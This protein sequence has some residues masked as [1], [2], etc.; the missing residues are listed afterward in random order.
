[1]STFSE[2]VN[3][4]F[5]TDDEIFAKNT[6][7]TR[8]RATQLQ[9][10]QPMLSATA[11]RAFDRIAEI[12]ADPETQTAIRLSLEGVPVSTTPI[13]IPRI[14]GIGSIRAKYRCTISQAGFSKG[15]LVS[16]L[17]KFIRRGET[18]KAVWCALEL[19][20]FS[21]LDRPDIL[22][23]Y[24]HKFHEDRKV[25]STVQGI[26]TNLMNRLNIISVEDVGLGD[27]IVRVVKDLLDKWNIG[28]R[29]N[30]GLLISAVVILSNCRKLRLLSDLKSV[31]HLP[32]YY[33]SNDDQET[34]I[35][36]FIKTLWVV[37]RVD[38][39]IDP[40]LFATFERVSRI[41]KDGISQGLKLKQI[42]NHAH[43]IWLQL[44]RHDNPEIRAL[45]G[46]F[47][48]AD[49]EEHPLYLYQA[50]LIH[51][52]K[53]PLP[54][55]P[56]PD[57]SALI[58]E[59]TPL[60]LNFIDDYCNDKHVAGSG[61][62][63]VVRFAEEGALVKN[64][65]PHPFPPFR[66]IYIDLKKAIEYN[67]PIA[68][69]EEMALVASGNLKAPLKKTAKQRQAPK[70]GRAT[71]KAKVEVILI[72]EASAPVARPKKT[73]ATKK[74]K[75]PC[76]TSG[77]NE[78]S[79]FSFLVRAQVL[80]SNNK[81]D[82]YFATMRERVGDFSKGDFVLVKGPIPEGA[83]NAISMNQWKRDNHLPHMVLTSLNLRPDMWS[84]GTPL[85]CRNKLDRSC[86]YP[87]LISASTL[88]QDVILTNTITYKEFKGRDYNP[89]GQ[90]PADTEIVN[91]H[92]VTSHIEFANK[93]F[94]LTS[95]QMQ[96]YVLLL[97]A[98]WLFGISDLADRNFLIRGDHVYSVDEEYINHP[99][100][101]VNELKTNKCAAIIEWLRLH[102]DTV[103][104]NVY[105]WNVPNEMLDIK[106]RTLL[107]KSECI[108]LF[109]ST[110]S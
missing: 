42:I 39:S 53:P 61:E 37:H 54:H 2:E 45:H 3:F 58:E 11:I 80:T 57:V 38:A 44:L 1:M 73:R 13:F 87:F 19:D 18:R 110:S 32:K 28:G 30:Q 105:R 59:L 81:A 72:D 91:W 85:G 33:G 24:T 104:A 22:T 20:G 106:K 4:I 94:K 67:Q 71:K 64:P 23:E 52:F 49:S 96:D 84:T 108:A 46:L 40:P 89:S 107:N 68:S 101:F 92:R 69:I 31:F 10:S 78:S 83:Q 60:T 21:M 34:L 100:N 63:S 36:S 55:V 27:P 103:H 26:R 16:A 90:W 41:Y 17:Q 70:T 93:R 98:R 74:A 62:K 9:S 109:S 7:G 50:I 35:E 8:E 79:M 47:K 88:P 97:L 66:S 5:L 77:E 86:V 56:V 51:H 14:P 99:V 15:L 29:A 43:E 65:A 48:Q 82:T 6:F 75:Y 12:E 102:Y 95:D 25:S 76:N